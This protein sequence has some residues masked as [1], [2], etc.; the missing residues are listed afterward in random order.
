MW[1]FEFQAQ[2]LMERSPGTPRLWNHPQHQRIGFP[3]RWLVLAAAVVTQGS[4]LVD[5][6]LRTNHL[7]Y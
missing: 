7:T 3:G 5:V 6:L 1:Q 4:I 2:G